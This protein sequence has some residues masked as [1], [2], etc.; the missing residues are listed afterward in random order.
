[1]TFIGVLAKAIRTVKPHMRAGVLVHGYSQRGKDP[2]PGEW[3][4]KVATGEQRLCF[5]NALDFALSVAAPNEKILKRMRKMAPELDV[6][7][8]GDVR[9]VHGFVTNVEGKRFEHAW[10]EIGDV[11]ADPTQGVR[12]EKGRWYDMLQAEPTA[13]YDPSEAMRTMIRVGNYGPW[14]ANKAIRTVKPHIRSG[15]SVHGYTQR[16]RD[17]KRLFEEN[18]KQIEKW[19][20][21]SVFGLINQ[22]AFIRAP[23]DAFMAGVERAFEA[24]KRYNPSQGAIEHFVRPQIKRAIQDHLRW[25]RSHGMTGIREVYDRAYG[26]KDESKKRAILAELPKIEEGDEEQK[27]QAAPSIEELIEGNRAL[28]K[29]EDALDDIEAKFGVDLGEVK[30]RLEA[31]EAK[32]KKWKNRPL[33][34]RQLQVFRMHAIE[35]L[36]FAE[37]AAKLGIAKGLA[38][39]DYN[40]VKNM[41]AEVKGVQ[42][43][44]GSSRLGFALDMLRKAVRNEYPDE[45]ISFINDVAV[46]LLS[47]ELE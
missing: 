14:D 9:L 47:D 12:M 3:Q 16:G 23:D 35:G 20:W 42:K 33:A 37:I 30:R 7:L 36:S 46:G 15:V 44:L 13:N 39:K 5:K 29:R 31:E 27:E 18:Y 4:G 6:R 25:E 24:L 11:V 45:F 8:K 41:L 28:L 19:A 26:T 1:M 2:K 38:F 22:G 32:R 40:T 17:A 21:E 43:S 34:E 10:V